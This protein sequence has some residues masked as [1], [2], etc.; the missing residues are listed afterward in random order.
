LN[1][2][3]YNEAGEVVRTLY[4]GPSPFAPTG[5]VA[6]QLSQTAGGANFPVQIAL[7]G[8]N[9]PQE[10]WFTDN[11]NGQQVAGGSYFVQVKTV[12][13]FG[14]TTT[15]TTGITVF[16]VLT[17]SSLEIFNSSGEMVSALDLSNLG[18]VAENFSVL[19]K[20][21]AIGGAKGEGFTFA[22]TAV[23]GSGAQTI[24]EKWDGMSASGQPASSGVYL[25]RLVTTS[26]GQAQ[27]IKII[28]VTLLASPDSGPK[29]TLASAAVAPL[30]YSPDK[31][32]G[33]GG[34]TVCYTPTAGETMEGR[35]YTLTGGMAAF[36]QDLE[37]A[38]GRF[39]VP[40]GKLASGIY[41]LELRLVQGQALLGRRVLKVAIVK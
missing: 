38:S 22:V 18:G 5:V 37:G 35:L 23:T 17:S 26:Q 36:G 3:I 30:P 40:A 24:A 9:G 32:L 31:D 25:V 41:L 7:V 14:R 27:V 1:I 15:Y 6:T 8:G 34:M 20:S 16:G 11:N 2:T 39:V 4:S 13:T 33:N 12:D 28:P 10:I 19:G 21:A 29:E